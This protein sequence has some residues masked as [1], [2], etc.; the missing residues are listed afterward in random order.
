MKKLFLV[1]GVCGLFA[2][3][4]CGKS[5]CDC[6]ASLAGTP[7]AVSS[8]T[9]SITDFDGDCKDVQWT[10]LSSEIQAVWNAGGNINDYT[11]TCVDH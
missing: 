9:P 6:E 7:A 10:D 1:L 11:L 3:A 2:L 4:S 8:T 5:D